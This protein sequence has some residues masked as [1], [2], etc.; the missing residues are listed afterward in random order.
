MDLE[1]CNFSKL[2]VFTAA[3]LLLIG[4]TGCATSGHS[5]ALANTSALFGGDQT[6]IDQ[7]TKDVLSGEVEVQS[8]WLDDNRELPVDVLLRAKSVN[9]AVQLGPKT[10]SDFAMCL[11]QFRSGTN[12]KDII[13]EVSPQLDPLCEADRCDACTSQAYPLDSRV[14]AVLVAHWKNYLSGKGSGH[15]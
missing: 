8:S 14:K 7:F 15:C 1:C 2:R 11:L 4:L 10:V 13:H 5:K 3:V 9:G 6:A 12:T